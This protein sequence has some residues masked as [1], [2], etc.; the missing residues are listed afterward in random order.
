MSPRWNPQS[1]GLNQER[2]GKPY[3]ENTRSRMATSSPEVTD[4]EKLIMTKRLSG[5]Q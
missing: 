5:I 3:L 1:N 4:L 2:P